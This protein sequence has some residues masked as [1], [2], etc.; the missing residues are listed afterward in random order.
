MSMNP[1]LL[2]P[3]ASGFNPRSIPNLELWLDASDA[4]TITVSTGVSVWAD[5]SG[6]GRN[7]TQATGGKQPAYTNTLNGKNIVTF[8]GTDDTLQ[9]AN[10]AAF[11]TSAVTYIIIARQAAANNESLFYKASAT[12]GIDGF[13]FRYRAGTVIWPYQKNDGNA[14]TLSYASNT[15]TNANIYSVTLDA[16]AQAAHV[17]GT[18]VAT[19]TVATGYS[20]TGPLWL[21]SRRDIGEFLN[22]DIAEVLFFSRALTPSERGRIEKA[23]GRKWGITVA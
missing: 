2:R 23:L 11:N 8:Q 7:A 16:S 10:N 20:D 21:G 9:I 14:A 19:A 6:N 12:S 3:L 5:K 22:G 13:I 1:R 4:S 18:Q 15:N 17:N